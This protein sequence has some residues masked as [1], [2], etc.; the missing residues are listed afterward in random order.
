MLRD[1]N[2]RQRDLAW[3]TSWNNPIYLQMGVNVRAVEGFFSALAAH[4]LKIVDFGCGTKPY[5]DY[6]KGNQYIGIDID[7]KNVEADIFSSV[8]NVPIE[9]DFADLV[10]SFH[11]LEH[12]Y[13]PRKVL[14]EMSRV[15]KPGGEAFLTVPFLWEEHEQPYDFYRFTQFA[16]INLMKDAGF[17]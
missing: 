13:E 10:C 14:S 6:A 2:Q 4:D 11:V 17:S 8:E 9:D 3:D 7:T 15:L 12:T 16:L 5:A 1:T